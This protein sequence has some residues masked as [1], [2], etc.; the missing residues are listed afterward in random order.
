MKTRILVS[1]QAVL[2]MNNATIGTQKKEKNNNKFRTN[3]FKRK[4]KT[5]VFATFKKKEGK[6][7]ELSSSFI[8]STQCKK[9]HPLK[10]PYTNYTQPVKS[11]SHHQR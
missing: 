4:S 2:H 5:I 6:E 9:K 10:S 3:A 7:G 1:S 11:A 8:S